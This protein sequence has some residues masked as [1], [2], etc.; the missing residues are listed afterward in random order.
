MR[1]R[2]RRPCIDLAVAH[3]ICGRRTPRPV[4]RIKPEHSRA[5]RNSTRVRRHRFNK[6]WRSS[7]FSC[8]EDGDRPLS[9]PRGRGRRREAETRRFRVPVPP[10]VASFDAHTS[11]EAAA[12]RS[13]GGRECGQQTRC[14]GLGNGRGWRASADAPYPCSTSAPSLAA[15]WPTLRER[16]TRRATAQHASA[17]LRRCFARDRSPLARRFAAISIRPSADCGHGMPTPSRIGGDILVALIRMFDARQRPQSAPRPRGTIRQ[18]G[19]GNALRLAPRVPRI[20]HRHSGRRRA[21]VC[22]AGHRALLTRPERENEGTM[23]SQ[24]ADLSI[25]WAATSRGSATSCARPY[26]GRPA[27]FGVSLLPIWANG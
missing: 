5:R 4:D 19:D 23:L 10:A 17:S 8:S 16:V 27:P 18:H 1:V 3:L 13:E 20:D 24:A 22:S 26:T 12:R 25:C 11:I 7:S 15:R 2:M 9:R 21:G 14:S 6:P